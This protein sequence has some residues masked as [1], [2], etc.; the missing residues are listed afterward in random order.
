MSTHLISLKNGSTVRLLTAG[1]YCDGDI[2]VEALPG[3]VNAPGV[4][5]PDL[6]TPG[7]ASDLM[8]GKQLLDGEGKVVDGTFTITEE[9]TEQDLL[10]KQI[11]IAL[12]GKVA[13]SDPV[14]EPLEVTENGTYTAPDGVHG[15]SPVVV[16]VAA[17]GGNTDLPSGYRRVDYIQFTGE[18][19]VDTGI[20]CNK[21]TQIRLAFTRE[22]SSQH[23]LLGVASSGNTASVTAYMG[24]SWRFGNKVATK[25][26]TTNADMIYSAVVDSSTITI[27]GSASA[28]S[29]VNEF[30]SVGT[31]I[32]GSCRS[33]D[34]TISDAQF[35]GKVFFFVMYQGVE[36]VLH[37]VPV[38]D[39]SVYRFWDTVSE[40]F[41][42]SITD[43]PLEG[44]NV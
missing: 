34:G 17:S 40:T 38:T 3:D 36:R 18:Q 8:A 19:I 20:I 28:I 44:G 30:E 7:A 33:S 15:F 21:N 10:I 12:Q 14:I 13:A 5:L 1:K 9:I 37:L 11:K 6:E 4:E 24:G 23:Y 32:L 39:G 43:V 27:T 25:T 41:F 31:L 35:V 26:P 16:N 42:D 29:S 22:K 2:L